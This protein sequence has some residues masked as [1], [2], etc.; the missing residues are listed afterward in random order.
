[1]RSTE[2]DDGIEGGQRRGELCN[3]VK[4]NKEF[5]E[6]AIPNVSARSTWTVISA[7][8]VGISVV[9]MLRRR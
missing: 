1:M 2:P 8:V 5:L 7:L 9:R 6:Q 3:G 4:V